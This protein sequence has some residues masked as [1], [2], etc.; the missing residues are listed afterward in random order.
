MKW[1]RNLVNNNGWLISLL[2][3]VAT[4]LFLLASKNE[5]NWF[6][7]SSL[8]YSTFVYILIV[9]FLYGEINTKIKRWKIKP[10]H[11]TIFA[12]IFGVV[13]VFVEAVFLYN[14]NI[15]DGFPIPFNNSGAFGLLTF[16]GLA[17][18]AM[19]FFLT[20]LQVKI[21]EDRI[22]GY[23][24]LYDAIFSLIDD[25]TSDKMRKKSNIIFQYYGQTPIPG[26]LS[27]IKTIGENKAS[28]LIKDYQD[29]LD[30]LM[31]ANDLEKK[32]FII[33]GDLIL[34][35]SYESVFSRSEKK[36]KDRVFNELKNING[37][38][39]PFTISVLD[40]KYKDVIGDY[41]FSNGHTA[42]FAVS[43][44]YAKYL[45]K[46]INESDAAL[47]DKEVGIAL[48]GFKTTDR[49]IVKELKEKFEKIKQ[50][51]F[52]TN[53]KKRFLPKIEEELQR[54]VKTLAT[55]IINN[56][57]LFD[58]S[59]CS[60]DKKLNELY[61]YEN[62]S[63]DYNYLDKFIVNELSN[64]ISNELISE[65]EKEIG[66]KV[67]FLLDSQIER[68]TPLDK[69]GIY[70]DL[71][72]NIEDEAKKRLICTNAKI[73]GSE[74]FNGITNK[75]E[76]VI[77]LKNTQNALDEKTDNSLYKSLYGIFTKDVEKEIIEEIKIKITEYII[78]EF[79]HKERLYYYINNYKGEFDL[80][81]IK[82]EVT[83]SYFET[84]KKFTELCCLNDLNSSQRR[85]KQ[86]LIDY[87]ICKIKDG[88][89]N[90]IDSIY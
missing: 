69:L 50:E 79:K 87:I 30:K 56:Q 40:E 7:H 12:V 90:Q 29:R 54:L 55:Q 43:L 35:K 28:K 44:H 46:T 1:I 24:E 15:E 23:E 25:T 64:F 45:A 67:S 81:A 59:R 34:N 72:K 8:F 85:I 19:G 65:V 77:V 53:I 62:E 70:Y 86:T 78:I 13:L 84:I 9:I 11:I 80:Q 63:N 39:S 60:V 58:P 47:T 83:N 51:I 57:K 10:I 75:P 27:I 61:P 76:K 82:N 89:Q 6:K 88:K 48:I 14:N 52:L 37:T 16:V 74:D 22:F 49:T 17:V 36:K 33:L 68:N 4:V 71:D 38:I 2:L 5:P 18:T 3:L 41:Y 20:R 31:K 73:E 42:I 32:D 21:M 66:S 26:H